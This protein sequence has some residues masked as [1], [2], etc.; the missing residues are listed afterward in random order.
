MKFQCMKKECPGT[1]GTG[2]G[3]GRSALPD[4]RGGNW[5]ASYSPDGRQKERVTCSQEAPGWG[6]VGESLCGPGPHG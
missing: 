3:Q 6:A 2:S 4:A 1:P 5:A